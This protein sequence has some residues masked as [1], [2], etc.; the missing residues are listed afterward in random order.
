MKK[1]YYLFFTIAVAYALFACQKINNKAIE[2]TRGEKISV[3]KIISD[4]NWKKIAEK[5]NLFIQRLVNSNIYLENLASMS[6]DSLLSQLKISKEDY[7][8]DIKE[9]RIASKLLIKKFDLENSCETCGKYD[10]S[11]IK[12]IRV[13]SFPIQA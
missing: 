9:V 5:N 6:E 8:E 4:E 1:I 12:K 3:D 2:S 13:H 7:L 11:K 10:N